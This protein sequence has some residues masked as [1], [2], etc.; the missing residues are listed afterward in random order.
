MACAIPTQNL[1]HIFLCAGNAVHFLYRTQK[2][3]ALQP[4]RY[5][6]FVLKT[7]QKILRLTFRL[8]KIFFA[9][10]KEICEAFLRAQNNVAEVLRGNGASHDLAKP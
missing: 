2:N 9:F 1:R 4:E 10:D 5:A 7:I 3:V 6:P 8:F